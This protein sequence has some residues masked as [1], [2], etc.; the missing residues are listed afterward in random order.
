MYKSPVVV[1]SLVG[2]C[3]FIRKDVFN[4][5][6]GFDEDYFFF[7]EETDLCLRLKKNKYNVYFIPDSYVIHLQGKSSEKDIYRIRW[8][9]YKS[10]YIFLRKNFYNDFQ[11]KILKVLLCVRLLVN[12]FSCGIIGVISDKEKYLLKSKVYWHIFTKHINYNKE[13]KN[14]KEI[15]DEFK[16]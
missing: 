7:F 8:E 13:I 12:V 16:E 14:I 10:R 3:M 15:E 5:L 2:A 11:I 4:K 1:E 9:Y 6:K